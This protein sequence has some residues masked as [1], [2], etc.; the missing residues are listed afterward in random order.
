M[1]SRWTWAAIVAVPLLVV[2]AAAASAQSAAHYPRVHWN[3]PVDTHAR[4]ALAVSCGASGSCVAV[5]STGRASV[6]HGRTWS[7]PRK[8][9]PALS[10]VS[11]P[12]RNFCMALGPTRYVVYRNGVWGRAHA[13]PGRFNAADVA[14]SDARFCIL[15]NVGPQYSIFNG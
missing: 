1:R 12:T 5:T 6:L 2:S 9:A 10:A 7:S 15:V 3:S 14:C 13:V 11:C 8:I 4:K